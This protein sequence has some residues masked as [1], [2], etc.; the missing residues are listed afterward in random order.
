[1]SGSPLV[2]KRPA[3]NLLQVG[4]PRKIARLAR[5]CRI[6]AG[7]K[8]GEF[9]RWKPEMSL[10]TSQSAPRLSPRRQTRI[11]KMASACRVS[12][13]KLKITLEA[14]VRDHRIIERLVVLIYHRLL[15][16]FADDLAV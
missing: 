1:M 4:D 12:R 7:A 10:G 2:G 6:A 11:L 3:S 5:D 15:V 13:Q 14:L 9:G 8:H 16:A